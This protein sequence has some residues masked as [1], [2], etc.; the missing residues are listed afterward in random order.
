MKTILLIEDDQNLSASLTASL[1]AEGFRIYTA[2]TLSEARHLRE[3]QKPDLLLLDWMLPDGQGIDY[4]RD[5]RKH[6]ILTPVILLTSRAAL[7][8]KIVGLETGANDYMTKPFEP[9]EL[10]ARIRTHLR[11]QDALAQTPK[12][13]GEITRAGI[14]LSER[15]HEVR[16]GGAVVELTKME[17][18]LLK[19]F[20]E[21]PGRVFPR[22]SLLNEVWGYDNYPTTR[23]I[24]NH[25]L[26]LRQKFGSEKFETV[27]GVGYRFRET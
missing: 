7:V 13:Q 23:T 18:H 14:L 1:S 11:T 8:D 25:I 26:Q 20:L 5:L 10:V 19:L 22:E 3:Q 17:Y 4:L 24:D 9:R 12:E 2:L 21:N 6:E 16:Y 27:R 15:A